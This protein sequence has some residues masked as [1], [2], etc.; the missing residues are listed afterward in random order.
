MLSRRIIALNNHGVN[1]LRYGRFNEA[2]LS[3]H[4]A[5][6]CTTEEVVDASCKD[7][8]YNHCMGV[9]QCSVDLLDHA[10]IMTV[11]PHNMFDIYQNAFLLSGEHSNMD[12]E[13]ISIVIIYNLA[14]AHHLAG[15]AVQVD[16]RLQLQEAMRFY[17]L[18]LTISKSKPETSVDFIALTLG[19]L[20]N[21]GHVFSHFW[22]VNEAEACYNMLN[23]LL[24][25]PLVLSLS[26]ED[27]DFFFSTLSFFVAQDH[28]TLAPAA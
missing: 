9:P 18:V 8:S 14:L 2:I 3:F 11:S 23:G 10:T 4:H 6:Q 12:V 16:S 20:T 26:E 21:L 22:Q 19:C 25:S 15:I 28:F 24:E 13:E 27:G 1:S 5:I 17:K 7:H